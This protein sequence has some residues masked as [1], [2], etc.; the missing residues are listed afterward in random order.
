MAKKT[1]RYEDIQMEEHYDLVA[2]PQYD[3]FSITVRTR[4]RRKEPLGCS[5]S[6]QDAEAWI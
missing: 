4:G 2:E 1:V 3:L 5:R 6:F